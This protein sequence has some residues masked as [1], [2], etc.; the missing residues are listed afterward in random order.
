M[1]VQPNKV[2]ATSPISVAASAI[3]EISIGDNAAVATDL[4]D[5]CWTMFLLLFKCVPKGTNMKK[6]ECKVGQIFSVSIGTAGALKLSPAHSRVEDREA[7][8]PQGEDARGTKTKNLKRAQ[9]PQK[10]TKKR[11]HV[12]DD[13]GGDDGLGERRNLGGSVFSSR[14]GERLVNAFCIFEK[15]KRDRISLGL[16][17]RGES[18]LSM[19]KKRALSRS[20]G[21]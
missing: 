10:D 8:L 20:L 9:N 19:E 11:N 13:R 3:W 4:R 7:Q 5:F 12:P 1:R 18:S 15:K 14:K 16:S 6:R 2:V 21:V 17:R